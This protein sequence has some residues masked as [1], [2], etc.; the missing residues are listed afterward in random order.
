MHP[1][2]IIH[3]LVEYRDTSV[4]AQLGLPDMR[5]PIAVAMAYPERVDLE[6]P[7]LQLAEIARLGVEPYGSEFRKEILAPMIAEIEARQVE[8]TVL[9]VQ[10]I[11]NGVQLF[12]PNGDLGLG[13][14][15]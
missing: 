6:I 10:K 14:C 4:I 3:S 2:S 5:V 12:T 7:R 15:E 11:R 13:C 8:R 9:D 1:Q